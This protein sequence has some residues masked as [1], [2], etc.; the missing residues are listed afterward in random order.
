MHKTRLRAYGNKVYTNFYG[1]N[2]PEANV[3]YESFTV[4]CID[5][6]FVYESKY[7]LQVY[8]DNCVYNIVKKQ[9]IDYLDDSLFE[10]DED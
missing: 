10:P 6:L 5:S 4:I 3:E 2:I 1:L 8:L 7:C 9:M